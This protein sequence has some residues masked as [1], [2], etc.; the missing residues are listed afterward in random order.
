MERS[1]SQKWAHYKFKATSK[2]VMNLYLVNS[3]E[4]SADK[5]QIH[6]MHLI[7]KHQMFLV[8]LGF[9][10]K[11]EKLVSDTRRTIPVCFLLSKFQHTCFK[12]CLRE[13][14]SV[15]LQTSKT[16]LKVDIPFMPVRYIAISTRW[17]SLALRPEQGVKSSPG[18]VQKVTRSTSEHLL[19]KLINTLFVVCSICNL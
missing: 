7:K 11:K 1:L 16:D 10:E 18:S 4:S 6:Q 12:S 15:F 3:A 14:K 17:L 19:S 9:V 2:Q 13:S 8:R 5:I